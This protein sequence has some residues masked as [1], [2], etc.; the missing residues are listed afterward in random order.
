MNLEDE[1][2]QN[3]PQESPEPA[4]VAAAEPPSPFKAAPRPHL[5]PATPHAEPYLV[6]EEKEPAENFLLEKLMRLLVE[7]LYASWKAAG[8]DR[9]F[10]AFTN[11]GL[12]A[13]A[14]QAPFVPDFMLS[15]DVDLERAARAEVFSYLVWEFGKP[16]DLIVELVSDKLGGEETYKMRGYARIGVSYYAIYDP[17]N[18][19]RQGELRAFYLVHGRYEPIDPAWLPGVR[20]GLTI[21]EGEF[22]GHRDRWLRWIDRSGRRLLTDRERAERLA[23]KLR[24][25]G[26]DPS[27]LENS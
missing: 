1:S 13:E 14:R 11:V 8:Q 19:L 10:A 9:P 4:T 5:L 23:E 20:L 16:P 3:G 18:I 12:F 22:E 6:I 26:I 7:I 15:L 2:P 24:S 17:R 21:W 27:T 25:L